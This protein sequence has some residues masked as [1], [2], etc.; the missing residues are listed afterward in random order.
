MAPEKASEFWNGRLGFDHKHTTVG[1][2][3]FLEGMI[4]PSDLI[5][6]G[7][8]WRAAFTGTRCASRPRRRRS[9]RA[10]RDAWVPLT[11][12]IALSSALP[13]AGPTPLLSC[14]QFFFPLN[15]QRES[16][17]FPSKI[18]EQDHHHHLPL[19]IP[20]IHGI[21]TN[22]KITPIFF[23]LKKKLMLTTWF[24]Q[25][26]IMYPDILNFFK[27][28]PSYSAVRPEGGF[29]VCS[30]PVSSASLLYSPFIQKKK[31]KSIIRNFIDFCLFFNLLLLQSVV[32]LKHAWWQH[33]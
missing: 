16:E 28:H 31:K 21:T 7:W 11:C 20:T 30:H 32:E 14:S 13:S 29:E 3:C 22:N 2:V 15:K 19:P 10:G 24:H 25:N 8:R 26:C 1:T 18:H 33:F 23:F 5:D 12:W 9:S 6:G 4:Q 27:R 17:C